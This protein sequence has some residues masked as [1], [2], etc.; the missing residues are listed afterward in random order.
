MTDDAGSFAPVTP[1]S[2]TVILTVLKDPRVARTLESLLRQDRLPDEILVDDGGITDEVRQITERFHRRD[3]RIRHL[4]APGNIPE[5][6]NTALRTSRGEF[7]AFL[8]A[9]EVAPPGWLAALLGPFSDP[10]VGFTGGPTPAMAGTV[11]SAG[12]S[13]YDGYL[14]RFYETEARHHPH[15]LPMGNSA[16][17]AR[18]FREVGALDT[19]L[20]RRAASEDQDVADR[21]LRAGWKGVFVPEG[22]VDHD[23]SDI[24]TWGLLRKQRVYAEGGFVVWRRRGTTYEASGGRVLPYVLLPLLAVIGAL[25]CLPTAS[26]LVGELLFAVGVGGLGVLALGLTLQGFALDRQYP[27]LR[28]RALEI[29][30]RWATLYGAFRG[31]LDYG[32]SGRRGSVPAPTHADGSGKR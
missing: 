6:R 9:D 31:L 10:K 4:D 32:W 24:T 23:F 27:G 25:L 14:R 28:Y 21:A 12:A 18:V 16:W 2:V 13:Y 3:P 30:R 7:V 11:R 19:T 29:P 22:Y 5:S 20:Y 1:G 26:R 8:D 15:A 17:R